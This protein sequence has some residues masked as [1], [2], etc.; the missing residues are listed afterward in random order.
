MK[1]LIFS[2][3]LLLM[4]TSGANS[5][6][7]A[8]NKMYFPDK[9]TCQISL[10]D[11]SAIYYTPSLKR[12]APQAWKRKSLEKSE[13][14][15]METVQGFQFVALPTGFRMAQNPNGAW[16][17]ELCTNWTNWTPVGQSEPVAAQVPGVVQG[18]SAATVIQVQCDAKCE[19]KKVCDQAAGTLDKMNQS[20][21]WLCLLPEQ[22]IQLIQPVNVNGVVKYQW[23]GWADPGTQVPGAN[24][25]ISVAKPATTVT[26]TACFTQGCSSV[27]VAEFV[28]EVKSDYCGIRTTDARLFKLGHDKTSGLVTVTEWTNGEGSGYARMILGGVTG[29]DCDKVQEVVEKKVW[30]DMTKHFR[31]TNTCSV[32][33]KLANPNNKVTQNK[34]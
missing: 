17:A 13:C 32:A 21:E 24:P 33:Q 4:V 26:G 23:G 16:H 27:P 14:V 22:K 3:F 25:R 31:M 18:V 19:A 5:V 9:A 28:Q 6:F 10:G 7:A 2:I 15:Q 1:K 29:N 34:N 11:N 20:G 12:S 30:S 8:E